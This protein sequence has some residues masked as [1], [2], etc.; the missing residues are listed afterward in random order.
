MSSVNDEFYSVEEE[1]NERKRIK[2][3]TSGTSNK[4]I[5][6]FGS[7]FVGPGNLLCDSEGH[8]NAKALPTSDIDK[9]AFQHDADYFN[10]TDVSKDNIWELDKKAIRGALQVSDPY[11]GNI[12]TALGLIAKRG[13]D[14]AD[15]F[16]TGS[17]TAIYPNKPNTSGIYFDTTPYLAAADSSRKYA[18]ISLFRSSSTGAAQLAKFKFIAAA[19]FARAIQ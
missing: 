9:V 16:L 18:R 8:F 11:Y 5:T 1:N 15:Q 7:S 12:A 2:L 6:W 10:A 19:L 13:V 4:G 3:G 14:L 17:E